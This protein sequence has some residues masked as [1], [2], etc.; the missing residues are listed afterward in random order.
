MTRDKIISAAAIAALIVAPGVIY[1]IFLMKLMCFALFA[2]AFNLLVGFT[3]LISFGHAAFL[4]MGGYIASYVI[5]SWGLTPEL[6]LLSAVAVT[7]LLGFAMGRLAIRSHGIYFSMI[8]LA[9]AQLVYFVC[10]Q[11]PFTGGEDGIQGVPRGNLFGLISLA[12]D[13]HAYYFI[14]AVCAFGFLAIY[15]I[16]H[17]PF[18]S[19]LKSIRENE[20]RAVS[21]GYDV[22]QFKL[23]TFVLSAAISGLAGAAK[24]VVFGFATL[25]DVHWHT[26]GDVVL[27]TLLGGIGT[28]LGPVVGS[29]LVVTLQSELADKV[30]S[31]VT[32]IMGLVFIACVLSF[33]RGIVGEFNAWLARRT[34]SRRRGQDADAR[35][36]VGHSA[37]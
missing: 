3:G 14:L 18:G 13:I 8:T 24:T 16:V 17:S 21:L 12:N 26:S 37:E 11:A 10:L 9:L 25:N 34:P 20:Q 6:A 23:V 2:C 15:R 1:P 33:R 35:V 30:G 5:K 36:V 7:A 4:G 28:I 27:M 22:D 31:K 19:I 32:I 29:T